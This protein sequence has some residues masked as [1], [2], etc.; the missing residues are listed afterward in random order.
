MEFQLSPIRGPKCWQ[1]KHS[2]RPLVGPTRV[3]EV[4]QV[5][6]GAPLPRRA[7]SLLRRPPAPPVSSTAWRPRG[8]ARDSSTAGRRASCPD[9][10][11]PSRSFGEAD[12]RGSTCCGR[13][14]GQ[15]S[16][17][18]RSPASGA[19][20]RRLQAVPGS[21]GWGRRWRPAGRVL[22]CLAKPHGPVLTVRFV[23]SH[24][25]EEGVEIRA[26]PR[27]GPPPATARRHG[28]A[29]APGSGLGRSLT[30]R[31]CRAPPAE[32]RRS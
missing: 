31:P 20:L 15:R 27:V 14:P 11:R 8:S 6:T 2:P 13:P 32:T 26:R 30:A 29:R 22:G 12:H 23:A 21:P 19:R 16:G 28:G 24:L 1:R 17:T 25:L 18:S 3:F 9:A 5:G 7:S 10:P 4:A